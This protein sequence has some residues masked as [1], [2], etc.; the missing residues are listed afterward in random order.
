MEGMAQLA[1]FL[2]YHPASPPADSVASPWRRNLMALWFVEFTAIFGF[3]FAAPFLPIYLRHDLGMGSPHDL[4]LW[5]GVIGGGAGLA[6]AV[7]SPIWGVIADRRGRK[8]MLLRAIACGAVSVGLMSF[9]QTVFTM[10]A[11]GAQ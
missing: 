9:A 5:A 3:S 6:M 8:T 2:P 11:T 1:T 10:L 4:A 7:A